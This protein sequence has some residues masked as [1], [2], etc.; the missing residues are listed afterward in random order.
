M[1]VHRPRPDGTAARQTQRRFALSCDQR[2]EKQAGRA[3][4]CSQF[5][6]DGVTGAA[7]RVY[8]DACAPPLG[9]TAEAAQDGKRVRHVE[10]IWT[11]MQNTR[12]SAQKRRGQ[13]GQDAVFCSV[14]RHLTGKR[15]R[16]GHKQRWHGHSSKTQEFSPSYALCAV[17]VSVLCKV[18]CGL[19]NALGCI[20]HSHIP[21]AGTH[22]AHPSGI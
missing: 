18:E 1:I 13:N 4:G 3:H 10:N 15:R 22:G 6:R 12:R 11:V 16:F 7:A 17:C 20:D 14:D 8:V 2:A 21:G 19:I 9:R 5:R